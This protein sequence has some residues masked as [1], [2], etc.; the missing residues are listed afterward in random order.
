MQQPFF[1]QVVCT[2]YH[3]WPCPRMR[4]LEL[5][6]HNRLLWWYPGCTGVKTG[7]TGPG[8]ASPR[9]RGAMGHARSHRRRHAR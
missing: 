7:Y 8:A 6:N 4:P 3:P 5:R 2:Q 1:R 9:D